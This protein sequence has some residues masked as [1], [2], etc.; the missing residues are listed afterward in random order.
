MGAGRTEVVETIFGIRKRKSGIIKIR[1]QPISI[2]APVDAMRC[3]IALVG[4]DRKLTGLNL[5]GSV[6]F[7]ISLCVLER[8]AKWGNVNNK[9]EITTVDNSISA[10]RIKTPDREQ[11][12]AFLSGGNQQKVVVAK[13]LLT[14]PDIFIMDEPTRGIDVGA[15]KEIYQIIANLAR[16]QKG[17]IM[18]SSELP[19]ILGLCDRVL[20][21]HEGHVMGLLNRDEFSQEKIM[22][23]AT[24]GERASA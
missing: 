7:N 1:Q 5:K 9:K 20:V 8:F 6:R 17:I 4:E 14:E 3:G 11:R 24:G 22:H 2:N 16:R 10:L 18:V 19:E 13:W 21:M 23:L 15:K 12:V